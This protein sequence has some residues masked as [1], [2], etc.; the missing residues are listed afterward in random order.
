MNEETNERLNREAETGDHGKVKVENVTG[1][2]HTLDVILRED[3][4]HFKDRK[5]WFSIRR[6]VIQ[7]RIM[8]Q[9]C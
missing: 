9:F 3:G 2:S 6:K 8:I 4:F 1:Q 5:L 7:L